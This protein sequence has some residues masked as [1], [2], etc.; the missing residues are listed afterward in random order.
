MKS[1][2]T[3]LAVTVG[4]AAIIAAAAP[5]SAADGPVPPAALQHLKAARKAVEEIAGATRPSS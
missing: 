4:C 3:I 2:P 1:P 5:T